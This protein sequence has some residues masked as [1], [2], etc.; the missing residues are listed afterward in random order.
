MTLRQTIQAAP[1]KTGELIKKL[2]ETTNQAVKT[3]EGLFA[4]LSDELTRYVEIEEQHF[5]PML[6]KHSGTKDLAADALKGNKELRASLKKLTEM[7]KDTD[8][9]LA[10][11]DVLNKSFQQHVRNERKELLPAVLKAFSDEEA[12]TLADNIDEAVAEAEKAKRDEQRE[13]NAK[14]KREAEEAEQAKADERAAARAQKA[15]ERTAREASEEAAETIARGAASVQDGARQVT[16]NIKDKTQKVASD[17]REAMTVYSETSQKIRDDVQAIRASSNVSTAAVS[18]IFS[19]WKE[20]FGNAARINADAAQK[21]MQA[22]TLQQ[23]AEHQNEF[24]TSAMRNWMEGNA[25]VLEISQ[26]SS[27]Q[28][29]APLN[30][31]L[32]DAA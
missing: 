25:K 28:A 5:L 20:W 31:R 22:R 10:E 8:E 29:L 27:K 3:R 26:R 15:A 17:T 1:G 30:G 9:F 11:I 23:V 16:A 14:A 19:A 2:S 21:L 4:Q 32:S 18:E 7:P 24:A 13:E 6:R 12:G